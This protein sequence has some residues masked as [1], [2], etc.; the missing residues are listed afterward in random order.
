MARKV[1]YG[2]IL[3]AA[4]IAA[5]GCEQSTKSSS[6]GT[7]GTGRLTLNIGVIGAPKNLSE[8]PSFTVFPGTALITKYTVAL[9]GA[10]TRSADT[11]TGS[12]EF[13]DLATGAYTITVT[14]FAG[15]NEVAVGSAEVTVTADTNIPVTVTIG[16]K[17][18]TGMATG[19]FKYTITAPATATGT[20]YIYQTDGVT[21]VAGLTQPYTLTGGA[22]AATATIPLAPGFYEA[23]AVLAL[24]QKTAG[25][26]EIVHIYSALTSE[27][28]KTF[29]ESDF[30]DPKKVNQFNL[31]DSFNAPATGGTPQTSF[32]ATSTHPYSGTIVWTQGGNAVSGNFEA[33]K[34]YQAVVTLT[35]DIGWTFTGV[36]ETAFTYTGVTNPVITSGNTGPT[37]VV[38]VIFPATADAP[39][40]NGLT[41]TIGFGGGDIVIGGTSGTNTIYQTGTPNSL[42]LTPDANYTLVR[43]VIDGA[44]VKTAAPLT[45][46]AAAYTLGPHTVT[47][48]GSKGGQFYSKDISFTVAA[49]APA[50]IAVT[51]ITGVPTT[52]TVGTA[53]SLSGALIQ[54]EGARAGRTITWSVKTAGTTGATLT[55]STLNTTA[56][57]AVTLTA[58]VANGTA[59]GTAF[60][61]DFTITVTAGAVEPP[62]SGGG[63]E[64]SE[65]LNAGVTPSLNSSTA[66]ALSVE[67]K[68]EVVF[69]V[70]GVSGTLT[71]AGTDAARV[72][73]LTTGTWGTEPA[74]ATRPIVKVN[75]ADMLFGDSPEK[76]FT[77]ANGGTTVTVT[78]DVEPNL[79]G[80]AVF[81]VT[82]D[83][84]PLIAGDEELERL[85]TDPTDGGIQKCT[86]AAAVYG[87]PTAGI[88]FEEQA[89]DDLLS[90]IA[91]I[92]RNAEENTDYLVRVESGEALPRTVLSCLRKTGVKVRLR[93][94]GETAQEITWDSAG[95]NKTYYNSDST[96]GVGSYSSSAYRNLLSVG[97]KNT[98]A[99]SITLQL[100][101]NITLTD[102]TSHSTNALMLIEV[103]QNH[104]LN[105]MAGSKITNS[106]VGGLSTYQLIRVDNDTAGFRAYVNMYAGSEIS[107]NTVNSAN[108]I[109]DF[110]IEQSEYVFFKEIGAVVN[111]N[112][113]NTG[114][115]SNS[116]AVRFRQL[117]TCYDVSDN[118][119]EYNLPP[120]P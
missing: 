80:V 76:T 108:G 19:N 59:V 49:T 89:G 2:F 28:T 62:P 87:D 58:T 107:G 14:G 7:K 110:T 98:I 86:V 56:A 91:W 111:N 31:T 3:A 57:G 9:S 119:T 77:L 13:L 60:T 36:T 37:I 4:V 68:P 35:A 99:G 51:D 93:G 41:I 120:Q 81:K 53:I 6:S 78:V 100:E 22:T 102:F 27:L 11:T 55:G 12:I 83:T 42:T 75:T 109:I 8:G 15:S 112:V 79:T 61:K 40:P 69:A 71:P 117:T 70:N 66:W 85:G 105:M 84:T 5:I 88:S 24:G 50:F 64:Y 115:T 10:A 44:E 116:N 92:D 46:T 96:N 26:S 23:R 114:G 72:T 18:G 103:N 29:A 101:K 113:D 97:V 54:P 73:V 20:L 52:G 38:T 21:P 106:N 45:L 32:P 65:V 67:E 95:G 16:P 33:S 30:A 34:V 47:F 94:Y 90:A 63:I 25:L 82:A 39:P 48:I 43:W 17:T 74:T 1:F 118:T 104:C